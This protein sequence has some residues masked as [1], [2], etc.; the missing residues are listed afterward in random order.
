[1]ARRVTYRRERMSPVGAM[2]AASLGVGTLGDM[3]DTGSSAPGVGWL[4]ALALTM[5]GGVVGLVAD[6]ADLPGWLGLAGAVAFIVGT[7]TA[8]RFVFRAS[9]RDGTS[10]CP[11]PCQSCEVRLRL[12]V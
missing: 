7:A 11:F 2:N 10:V 6:F 9:R 1:M 8:V 12:D 3:E 4:A 5:A